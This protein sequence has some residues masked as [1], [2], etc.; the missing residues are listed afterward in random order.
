MEKIKVLIV[1]DDQQIGQALKDA[2][3]KWDMEV[4]LI[5]D[6][7]EVLQEFIEAA[8]QLV[9]MDIILPYYNGYYWCTKIRE[10]SNVPMI[11]ISSKSEKMDMVMAMQLGGDD[12]IKKPIDLTL[13]I[14]KIQALLRRSYDFIQDVQVLQYQQV[15]LHLDQAEIR[16]ANE[17]M[18]LTKT[19]CQIM[20]AL[21]RAKGAYV[22]RE[23]IME[24]CWH[25]ENYIDDNTLAVN[26]TRLRKKLR[27]IKLDDFIVTKKGFGYA[28]KPE[29]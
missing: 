22:S 11:F 19:E 20:Q 9:L 13:T 25:G 18:A 16:Y 8:P 4:Q 29:A 23:K 27:E 28:L 21:F 10:I 6:F 1:E 26:M 5:Q 7:G 24:K 15:Q 2:L 14:A 17:R 3:E 12:Y